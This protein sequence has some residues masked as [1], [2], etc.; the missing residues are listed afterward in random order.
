[1]STLHLEIEV[2]EVTWSHQKTDRLIKA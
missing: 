1:M 2:T